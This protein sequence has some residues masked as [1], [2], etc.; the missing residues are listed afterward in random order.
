MRSYLSCKGLSTTV[1]LVA[2]LA[3][4]L[5]QGTALAAFSGV[6]W[7]NTDSPTKIQ[8][9]NSDG[10]ALAD[11]ITSGLNMPWDLAIDLNNG[12]MYW[13][14]I[15]ADK[16]CRANLDGTQSEELITT[17]LDNCTSIALDLDNGKIYW[18][19]DGTDKIQRANLDGTQ[20]EN[21]I[22][23]GLLSPRGLS[24]NPTTNRIYW[25]DEETSNQTYKIRRAHMD[26]SNITDLIIGQNIEPFDTVV[27]IAAGKIYWSEWGR[28]EGIHCANLNGTDITRPYAA[29]SWNNAPRFLSLD[30][31]AGKIYWT[32]NDGQILRANTDEPLA[33][34]YE[35]SFVGERRW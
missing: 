1:L 11:L 6:Y 24:L 12:K 16:I 23:T 18:T 28:A 7:T 35:N 17:G 22:T 14:D 31:T 9:I 26:G 29:G 34:P 32:N 13:A 30:T 2:V 20:V 19:D 10:S 33:K 21:I 25:S 27:D 15:Q 3:G 4:S 8:L 5:L